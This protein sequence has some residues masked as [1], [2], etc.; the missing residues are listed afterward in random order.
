MLNFRL[1]YRVNIMVFIILL[2][3]INSALAQ[4]IDQIQTNNALPEESKQ[5]ASPDNRDEGFNVK[6]NV[7]LVTADVIVVGDNVPKLKRDDFIVY[8]NNVVQQ[9]GF[10]SQEQIPLA[11]AIVIDCGII[12]NFEML[13]IP[14]LSALRNMKS[15][16]QV[17]LFGFIRGDH[18][19]KELTND[20]VSV[21]KAIV[22]LDVKNQ[23]QYWSEWG[24]TRWS[25]YDIAL[26]LKQ[27]TPNNRRAI[28]LISDNTHF[29]TDARKAELRDLLSETNTTL[30]NIITLWSR[31]NR[32]FDYKSSNDKMRQ[33]AEETGGAATEIQRPWG[34][35]TRQVVPLTQ[36]SISIND[37][38]AQS[39]SRL[40]TR[41][42]LGFNPSNPDT[43]KSFHKLKVQFTDKN[44]C[45][46][47]QIITRKGYYS[48]VASLKT[49]LLPQVSTAKET[50]PEVSRELARQS[51]KVVGTTPYD[52]DEIS[53]NLSSSEQIE[54]KQG[55]SLIRLNMEINSENIHFERKEGSYAYRLMAA[56][57]Y[58]DK[59]HKSS[60]SDT[61]AF[62][63]LL[64][65]NAH[66]DALNKGLQH[67]IEIPSKKLQQITKIVI[68]DEIGDR[69]GSR[70]LKRKGNK[71][72]TEY[73]SPYDWL[74]TTQFN[75]LA[76]AEPEPLFPR[77]K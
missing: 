52:F 46:N 65:E 20:H 66:Q 56:F 9:I 75:I 53:F 49:L 71:Y 10:F 45:P 59:W 51:I 19:L 72:V 74:Y 5:D 64:S 1:I 15:E 22:A 69:I 48:G 61:W 14:G 34:E 26:Y 23:L 31:G 54:N 6:V 68:Y 43:S 70:F 17:A 4:A 21:A 7:D 32:Y 76:G 41:Y 27:T 50:A 25:F 40:R 36:R 24:D 33:L 18:I 55:Q 44:R 35:T 3:I 16:D 67:S 62:S 38:V 39:I 42:T 30:Y 60:G 8:D 58:F 12:D 77:K 73:H 37:A 29:L 13:K 47:C 63:R 28:I 11:V 2:L 57:C